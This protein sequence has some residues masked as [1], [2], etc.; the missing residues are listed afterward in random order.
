ML[1]PCIGSSQGVTGYYPLEIGN[2][3]EYLDYGWMGELQDTVSVSVDRD[4][5]IAGTS[6]FVVTYRSF[7]FHL[8]SVSFQRI[9]T[10]GNV[11]K[12]LP[13]STQ[14]QMYFRFSDTSKT[15]WLQDMFL[16]R[17]DV[18]KMTTT[19]SND[20]KAFEVHHFHPYDSSEVIF[21]QEL[22]E[23]IGLVR[24][25]YD[26]LQGTALRG[27]RIGGVVHGTIS[28]VQSGPF[29]QPETFT[30]EQ[31]YP[32]PFNGQ[33]AIQFYLPNASETRVHIFNLL[34]QE[35]DVPLDRFLSPGW[36]TIQWNSRNLPSGIYIYQVR[37]K[38]T[39]LAKKLTILK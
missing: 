20:T 24:E 7:K 22:V 32:N 17:F 33:T 31:N 29:V 37:N 28:S 26:H 36:H 27:A 16:A 19:F 35:I 18:F 34:G 14:E 5:I 23:S 4:T 6:Y 39:V 13:D 38:S 21:V 9:D 30:L 2:Y 1:I 3:W 11:K 15:F 25:S 10:S 12:L 8:S